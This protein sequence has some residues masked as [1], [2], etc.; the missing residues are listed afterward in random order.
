MIKFDNPFFYGYQKDKEI[1]K[2]DS[3]TFK[4]YRNEDEIVFNKLFVDIVFVL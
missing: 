4:S 1:D 2:S 3:L